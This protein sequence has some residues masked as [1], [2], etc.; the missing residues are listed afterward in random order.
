MPDAI[1]EPKSEVLTWKIRLS[2]D[3]RLTL[4]YALGIASRAATREEHFSMAS[5]FVELAKRVSEAVNDGMMYTAH[6]PWRT[7]MTEDQQARSESL[8]G[9]GSSA[10]LR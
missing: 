5:R 6:L 8:I 2:E 1:D 4:V 7:D 10:G 3:E 9:Y